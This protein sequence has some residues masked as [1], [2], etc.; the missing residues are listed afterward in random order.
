VA[1]RAIPFGDRLNLDY[2]VMANWVDENTRDDAL[3]LT[4]QGDES[5]AIQSALAW[6][7][8]RD[9]VE[10]SAYTADTMPARR[11]GAPIFLL[12]ISVDD[13]TRRTILAERPYDGYIEI[14]R[15][16]QEDMPPAVLLTK[17]R[18]ADGT[19]TDS[20]GSTP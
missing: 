6:Y 18:F 9:F 12:L 8:R 17:P 16:E 7:T 19:R 4:A 1:T 13:S 14:A 15:F 10:Y 20:S 5:F 3:I 11:E 2:R